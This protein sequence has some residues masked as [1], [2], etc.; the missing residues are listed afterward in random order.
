M[1]V[2]VAVDA[3][4]SKESAVNAEEV[5]LKAKHN[6]NDGEM[7]VE[8]LSDIVADAEDPVTMSI[9]ADSENDD[10]TGT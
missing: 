6:I 2:L 5:D 9:S 1:V 4:E 8:Q 7:P 3:D 10:N